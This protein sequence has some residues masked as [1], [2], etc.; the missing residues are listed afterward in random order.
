MLKIFR[1]YFPLHVLQ[2]LSLDFFLLLVAV[3]ALAAFRMRGGEISGRGLFLSALGFA[4]AMVTVNFALGLYRPVDEDG[5]RAAFAR[6]V[7]AMLLCLPTAYGA[8]LFLPWDGF[9]SLS[10]QAQMLALVLIVLMLR[11]LLNRSQ[12]SS[13]FSPRILVVGT[14]EDALE[15]QRI[16]LHPEQGRVDV[17]AFFPIDNDDKRFVDERKIVSG[18]SLSYAA[19]QLEIDEIVVAVRERRGVELPLRELFDCKLSGVRILDLS[20]FYERVRRQVRLDSLHTSW[21]IYGDGFQQALGRMFLKRI[22][23]LAGSI[24]LLILV[25]PVMILIALLITF[26]DH[27]PVFYFQ[28]RI[29]FGGQLF[30][31]ARFRSIS[32]GVVEED[33]PSRQAVTDDVQFTKIG[34]LIRKLR[35]DRLPQL[36][37]VL[38]GD[39]SLVGPCPEQPYFVDQM[40]REIPFYS[41][42]HC[43]K[44]GLTGW[45]QVRYRGG[46]SVEDAIQKLQY[47]LYYIKNHTLVLDT[48]VL[49]ETMRVLLTG[50]GDR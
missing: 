34:R 25:S 12:A 30:R 36:L 16:L 38:S 14:G 19:R 13:L 11:V 6:F 5:S 42:R 20:S 21:L 29:G 24:A 33:N 7:L 49:L 46:V 48:L 41:V 50:K 9:A 32:V 4:M 44:P 31:I 26:E 39:M 8:M 3:V 27:G 2:R 47:D 45:S 15:V 10:M 37:N 23:D 43:V 28:E 1:H 18:G 17:R 22:F 35:V 40:A